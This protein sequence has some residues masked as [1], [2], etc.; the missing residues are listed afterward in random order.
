MSLSRSNTSPVAE[1]SRR[2]A[3]CRERLRRTRATRKIAAH[4]AAPDAEDMA[5]ANATTNAPAVFETRA[6][7]E[8]EALLL[9]SSP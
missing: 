7:I 9:P 2:V 5:D 8:E 6:Q 1:T 4:V 3:D